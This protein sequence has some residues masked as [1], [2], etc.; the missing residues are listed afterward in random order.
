M[1]LVENAIVDTSRAIAARHSIDWTQM[2]NLIHL[3][4]MENSLK[5]Q[6]QNASNISSRISLHSLYS[7]NPKGWFPWI[8]EQCPLF[9]GMRILD[10]AAATALCGRK[11]GKNS[12]KTSPSLFPPDISDGMIRDASALSAKRSPFSLCRR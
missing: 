4:G 12:P 2:L 9:P 8:Y 3:T 6:Y 7:Q 10:S 1:Q 11:T 5:T